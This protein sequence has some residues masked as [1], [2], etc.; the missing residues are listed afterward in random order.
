[1]HDSSGHNSVLLLWRC[2][3]LC[4]SGFLGDVVFSSIPKHRE[5]NSRNYCIG[6]REILLDDNDRQLSCVAG[7]RT[8]DEVCHLRLP[9]AVC[10]RLN[11]NVALDRPT[12]ACSE[13]NDGH[14]VFVAS[15]AVDGNNDTDAVQA[16]SSCSMS[17]MAANP[18]WAVDLGRALAVTGVLFTNIGNFDSIRCQRYGAVAVYN[19]QDN[20]VDVDVEDVLAKAVCLFAC[21]SRNRRST[22]RYKLNIYSQN[23]T[24]TSSSMYCARKSYIIS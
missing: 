15:R 1:M 20:L 16:G 11:V 4:T 12:F 23:L 24:S 21:F 6:R 13:W 8:G 10:G 3:S 22:I 2:D 5:Y 18:W 14:D 9:C 7:L 19:V 17:Y